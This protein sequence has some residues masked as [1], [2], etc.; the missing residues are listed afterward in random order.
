MRLEGGGDRSRTLATANV[1][2]EGGLEKKGNFGQQDR[3]GL[4]PGIGRSSRVLQEYFR[5]GG[6]GGGST[7]GGGKGLT[8]V[9]L[10]YL[11]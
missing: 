9:G 7:K 10:H 2:R 5:R 4:P 11:P 6:G 8:T 3:R 1:P